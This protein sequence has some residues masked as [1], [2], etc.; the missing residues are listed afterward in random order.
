[1]FGGLLSRNSR[2]VTIVR[3]YESVSTTEGM[4]ERAQH[5]ERQR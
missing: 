1:M 2:A 4:A 3:G 5:H